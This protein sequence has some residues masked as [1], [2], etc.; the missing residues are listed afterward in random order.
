MGLPVIFRQ[1]STEN[2]S[3]KIGAGVA[4]MLWPE[5]QMRVL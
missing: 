1:R 5:E 3:V 2:I 4:Q